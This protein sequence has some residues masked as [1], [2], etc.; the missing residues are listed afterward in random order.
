MIASSKR[1]RLAA[2]IGGTFTDVVLEHAGRRHSAK[3]LTTPRAPEQGM[4]EG[5]GKVLAAAALTPRDVGVLVHGTTLATNALIERKGAKTALLTTA[6]FRDVL[7]M[8]YEKRYEHYDLELELPTPLVPRALRFPVMERITAKGKIDTP[9]LEDSLSGIFPRLKAEKIEA[10]AIGFLHSYAN[11][12]HENRAAELLAKA[13]P[14]ISITLSSEVCP[15]IREYERFSTAC[16]NRSWRAT[17]R[18]WPPS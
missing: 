6:G 16:A 18:A 8:G 10:V 5:M 15:E 1:A 4:L 3:V 11:D 2:D 13:L 17:S 7:E 9:L 14:G 12:S